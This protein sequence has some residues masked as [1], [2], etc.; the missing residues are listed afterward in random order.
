MSSVTISR[1]LGRA[2]FAKQGV[3]VAIPVARRVRVIVSVWRGV[4]LM[5]MLYFS[6]VSDGQY[7]MDANRFK[8]FYEVNI[9]CGVEGRDIKKTVFWTIEFELLIFT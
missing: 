8:S 1:I 5:G 2:S 7:V 6:R 9:L 4:V 3:D